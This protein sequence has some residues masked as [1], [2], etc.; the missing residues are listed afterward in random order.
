MPDEFEELPG[1]LFKKVLAGELTF[2]EARAQ[3]AD[4]G[5]SQQRF[6]D[7]LRAA[8]ASGEL[9]SEEAKQFLDEIAG[10]ELESPAVH[11]QQREASDLVRRAAGRPSTGPTGDGS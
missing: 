11:D 3:L 8:A 1:Y 10:K 6:N 4:S 7:R 9:P 5:G 2:R